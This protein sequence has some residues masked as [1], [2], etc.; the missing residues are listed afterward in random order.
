MM[1]TS[2]I[3]AWQ[4]YAERCRRLDAE[5]AKSIKPWWASLTATQIVL[6]CTIELGSLALLSHLANLVG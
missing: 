2:T 1:R 6:I 4:V 3:E 5:E